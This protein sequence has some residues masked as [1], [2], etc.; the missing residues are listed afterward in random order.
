MCKKKEKNISTDSTTVS[1]ED[2][3]KEKETMNQEHRSRSIM[4]RLMLCWSR[5]VADL[6]DFTNHW[7]SPN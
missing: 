7:M 1:K 6:T 2:L 3:K 5:D 4:E